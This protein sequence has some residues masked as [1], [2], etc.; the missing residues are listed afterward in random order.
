GTYTIT[1]TDAGGCISTDTFDIL[2]PVNPVASIDA[3]SDL[4]YSSSDMATIVVGASGGAAPYYYSINGGP[5]QASNTFADLIPGNYTFTVIDSNG[6]TDTVAQLIEPEITANAV[7][8]KDL[9][10]TVSPDAVIDL[11]VTGG[12]PPYTYEVS[13]NAGGFAAYAG[14]F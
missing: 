13:I 3:A 14:G 1:I 8:T 9:D 4:C 11:T 10:C 6:C 12:Y 7:L 5:S 2:T